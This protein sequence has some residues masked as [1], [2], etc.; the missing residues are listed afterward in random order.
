MSRAF[1][2]GFWSGLNPI[3]LP[4]II[5]AEWCAWT[6]GGGHILRD[7]SGRVN[8]QCAKCGRWAD[9]VPL[10]DERRVVDGDIRGML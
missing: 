1:W 2:K 8:W 5:A 10:E 7:P 6:H 3:S 9:P 4:R